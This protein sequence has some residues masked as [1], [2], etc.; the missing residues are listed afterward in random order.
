MKISLCFYFAQDRYKKDLHFLQLL[1]VIDNLFVLSQQLHTAKELMTEWLQLISELSFQKDK[2]AEL[3]SSQ[4]ESEW[5]QELDKA[6]K[7]KVSGNTGNG[8]DGV[9]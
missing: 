9:L 7:L 8:V 2:L 5:R 6:K 3:G 1:A 4:K